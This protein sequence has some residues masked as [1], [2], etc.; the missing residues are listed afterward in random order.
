MIKE[1]RGEELIRNKKL[2][3]QDEDG[4]ELKTEENFKRRKRR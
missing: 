2:E 4:R 3:I 1:R